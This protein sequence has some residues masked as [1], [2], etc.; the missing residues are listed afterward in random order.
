[1]LILETSLDGNYGIGVYT[2]TLKNNIE[3][4]LSISLI[5]KDKTVYNYI[6][7]CIWI[8]CNSN[9]DDIFYS[10]SFIAPILFKGKVILTIHDLIHLEYYK[11]TKFWFYY[12]F[13]K[14][15]V[16]PDIIVTGSS[17]SST[18]IRKFF[19]KKVKIVNC[20]YC[21]NENLKNRPKK[22]FHLDYDYFFV[23]TNRKDHKNDI[24]L[25][26]AFSKSK[27][28]N[29][30]NLVFLGKPTQEVYQL[31]KKLNL[32]KKVYFLG[33]ITDEE[34]YFYYKYSKA[35][36]FISKIEGFGF[37]VIESIYFKKPIILSD[38]PVFKEFKFESIKF[39][40]HLE[41]SEIVKALDNFNN[42]KFLS[43]DLSQLKKYE[44]VSFLSNINKMLN[45]TK[46]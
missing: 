24:L 10:S 43:K 22:S 45:S 9:K 16:R 15:I 3:Y 34:L 13:L 4:D 28:K 46:K 32:L 14:Y 37:P 6:K 12:S 44:K 8:Y 19:G 29:K 27:S 39:I 41:L 31:I 5:S 17:Y 26:K 42:I 20:G 11:E 35:V 2:K 18:S 23:P 30:L 7:K 38:I 36:I 21:L 25:I 1:M 40:N 33:N